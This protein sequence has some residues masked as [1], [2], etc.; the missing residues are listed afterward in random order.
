[1]ATLFLVCA[2]VGGTI[3]IGQ[4]VLALV[5]FGGHDFDGDMPHDIGDVPHDVHLDGHDAHGPDQELGEHGVGHGNL[6]TW[7]FGVISFKTLTA[8]TAFFGLAGCAANAGQMSPVAQMTIAIAAGVGA[9]YSV[10][11]LMRSM[12]RLSE[13]GTLR[14]NRAVGRQGVVYLTI[15]ANRK[16]AGKVQ[17][18]LQNRLM[19]YQAVTDHDEPLA[20]GAKIQ[21]VGVSGSSVLEVTPW[22]EPKPSSTVAASA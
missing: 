17:I 19:E 20:T 8:A 3:L 21:V 5:G 14:V 2:A 13:D 15:P 4:F 7:L 6:S 1:M 10:H 9:M 18:Q 16:A 12:R 11:W 22:V